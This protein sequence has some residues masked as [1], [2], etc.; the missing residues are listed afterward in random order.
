M[1]SPTEVLAAGKK[2]L[3]R[4]L[5]SLISTPV[6]IDIH[7]EAIQDKSELPVNM[8]QGVESQSN[9]KSGGMMLDV[10]QITPNPRQPR[11]TFDEQSLEVLANSIKIAGLMQP[12]LVR[13][14]KNPV[15]AADGTFVRYELIAGERRWRAAQKAGLV[16]IPAIIRDV[17]ERTSAEHALIE[18]LQ[19][20]DL[21]PID[22]AEAFAQ[23][24]REFGLTHDE[25]ASQVGLDRSTITNHLRLNELDERIKSMVRSN[26]LT[27]GHA[28]ALLAITN[29]EKRSHFAAHAKNDGWSVRE[30]ERRIAAMASG[31]SMSAVTAAK[32]AGKMPGM[33]KRGTANTADLERRL[34]EYLGT[35]VHIEPGEKKGSGKL[36]VEFYS[37]DQ[38]DGLMDRMGFGV[39]DT[40]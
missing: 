17:D 4:G 5:G 33:P 37:L 40:Q 38:F 30:L 7:P 11:K 3:G 10:A 15:R 32:S 35:R 29:L 27:M 34:G 19:R 16:K 6:K 22:R 14:S 9:D 24:I 31:A 18:N 20:E 8:P 12:I 1:K 13:E 25:V 21:N 26:S 28:R 39:D 2:R 23:L 36:V